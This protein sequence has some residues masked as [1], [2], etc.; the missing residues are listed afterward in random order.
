M[1]DMT[2]EAE[3]LLH[4]I[5]KSF[6]P[7]TEMLPD[8]LLREADWQKVMEEAMSQA[9]L[10]SAFD[11]AACYKSYMPQEVY[12][13]WFQRV[14]KG[15]IANLRV[16]RMQRELT[17]LLEEHGFRH[18]ILKGEAS[19]AFYS[20]P[21]LR[22]LGDIDFLIDPGQ[23]DEIAA[24]LVGNGYVQSDHADVWHIGFRKAGVQ[25]EMHF[26]IPG[27]P[28]GQPG[29]RICSHIQNLLQ[30]T[31]IVTGLQGD[32]P[33]AKEI[34]HGLI[35]LL[36]MQQHMI[37]E[38]LGLRHLCDWA[39]FVNKTYQKDFWPLQ[40][41]PLLREL[42]LMKYTS[43][44]TEICVRY[45]GIS[46]PEWIG[47][48]T[49]LGDAVLHDIL[50][51]GNFGRKDMA[52]SKAGVIIA[53]GGKMDPQQGTIHRFWT[54]LH[55]STA[56]M[57]P[58]AQRSKSFHYLLDLYRIVLYMCRRALGKRPSLRKLTPLAQE[59]SSIYAQ[60]QIFETQQ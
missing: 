3:I 17:H 5:K 12:L 44:M 37:S 34:H 23:T 59:R 38:G 52:R 58:A 51:G 13:Y 16:S 43:V 47:H 35:L 8:A 7:E 29:E 57:Y 10:I 28:K 45:L 19:A 54:T 56:Q 40:L 33:A 55:Q 39:A 24:L 30:E 9:V 26:S 20:K 11:A 1:A 6:C 48:D 27:V 32:F 4:L 2:K 46:C 36:H 14:S 25:L 21:E 42:G 31:E 15:M 49:E 60:L 18:L 22:H 50:T 53:Q 41:L